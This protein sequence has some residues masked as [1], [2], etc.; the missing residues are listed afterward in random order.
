[1]IEFSNIEKLLLTV[2][3]KNIHEDKPHKALAILAVIEGIES[4]V[5]TENKIYFNSYFKDL[6]KKYFIKYS[7]PQDSNRPVNP[8][9]HLRSSSFWKLQPLI[10]ETVPTPDRD[11]GSNVILEHMRLLQSLGF[12]VTFLPVNMAAPS[13]YAE[14]LVKLGIELA[15]QPFFASPAHMLALRGAEF[16]LAYVHRVAVFERVLATLRRQAPQARVLFNNADLHFLRLQR[17]AEVTGAPALR[18]EAAEM[19]EREL[20][21]FAA[22][23][24]SLV[25]NAQEI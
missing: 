18:R 11:A 3:P 5:Y 14:A 7:R 25:C 10:D 22:A 21:A 24:A 6:F 20:R 4:G 23:D 1:M 8:F 12:A 15:A 2:L 9:F 17:E 13:P 16:G 19:G